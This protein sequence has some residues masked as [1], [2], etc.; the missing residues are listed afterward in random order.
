MTKNRLGKLETQFLAYLQMRK[1]TVV[2][3]GEIQK[4]LGL[5]Q[6]QETE[7]FRRLSRGRMIARV[8]PGLYLIPDRLPLGGAWAPGEIQALNALMEDRNGSYQIC[9]PNAFHRYGYDEQIPNRLYVYNNRISGDRKIGSVQLTLIEVSDKRLGET[10]EVKT[11]DG[12]TAVYSSRERT[13]FDAVY[14]WARFDTLPRAYAW[15]RA[16]LRAGRVGV[17]ILVNTIVRYGDVGT[18]R[19]FGFLL[20]RE[21]CD[22]KW[23]A[24]L[25][26][27]LSPS[28]SSIPWIPKRPKKGKLVHRWGVVDNE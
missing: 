19:R 28:K 17:G 1:K 3:A 23:L 2:K 13:L 26:R 6:A 12:E 24:K 5:T 9:G 18:R 21:G 25:D 20:E 10:V 15:I 16:D 4:S 27:S 7:L 11:A 8:R 14:D 22:P